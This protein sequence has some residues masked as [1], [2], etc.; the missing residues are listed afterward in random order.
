MDERQITRMMALGRVVVGVSLTV[1]P[2][3][4]GRAWF[5]P[6]AQEPGTKVAIRALGVR[7][8]A[9]GLGTHRALV[10]GEPVAGW[11]R[12]SVISDVVDAGATVL[13]I[14]H[15]GVRRA[16]PILAVATTA[17]VLGARF[18]DSVD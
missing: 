16:L 8:A 15:I 13:A 4:V 6:V 10:E 12:A 18:V 5:G 3:T 11:L 9:L 2:G 17:A 1:L 14:R 7:D